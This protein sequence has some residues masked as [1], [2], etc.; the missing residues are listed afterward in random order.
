[1]RVPGSLATDVRSL[2]ALKTGA[3][4]DPS[5]AVKQAA[6]QF[7]ALFMQMVLKSMR[8]AVPKSGMLEG[9]GADVYASMLDTQF[10]QAM[11]GR[12]GGLSDMIA[13]QL[14]RG[15]KAAETD[16]AAPGADAAGPKVDPAGPKADAAWLGSEPSAPRAGSRSPVDALA[17]ALLAQESPRGD[18]DE[19][20]L[21]P[22]GAQ[23]AAVAAARARAAVA[24]A[25]PKRESP[26]AVAPGLRPGSGGT[27]TVAAPAAPAA[28]EGSRGA[29]QSAFV[30]RLWNAAAAAERSTGVPAGFIVGQA[31]LETGWGRQELRHA[32]G[33]SANNLFGIKA[34]PGW[35]GDTVEST[36]TEYVDGRAM[37]T[38][39][40]FRAYGSHEES[41][42]DW[43]RL[44]AS[45]P[46]YAGV[47]QAGGS[48]EAFS[49]NLQKAGYATDP[50]YAS[51][52]TR[53]IT[54]A[55]TLRREST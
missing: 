35:R 40:R 29:V 32:D 4:K 30:D 33:R 54:Q 23:M 6:S 28:P 31:A 13:K 34:G 19:P 20:A 22:T 9:T 27:G 15:V 2:D 21:Y 44:M 3:A 39:E 24:A 50:E 42:A 47:L 49:R 41:V 1:M 52:L 53:T 37:K 36:T 38:V 43:A 10:A 45:N 14:M 46:R 12:P 17:R 5:G 18:D 26:D 16:A 48:I 51:K 8:D 7:E 55:L 25:D 11:S